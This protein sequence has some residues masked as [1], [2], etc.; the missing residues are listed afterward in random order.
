MEEL[1]FQ[2]KSGWLKLSTEEVDR[3]A[4]GYIK[5]I[6][7]C[8]TE[9]Q[10]VKFAEEILKREGFV[11]V[12]EYGGE[13]PAKVYMKFRDKALVAMKINSKL[14]GGMNLVASHIDS[15]RIDLKPHPIIEDEG[16]ALAKTHY[17]G[18]IK[19]Y[20]WF[21]IPLSIIGVVVKEDGVRIEI[22]LG[23]SEDDPVFVISDLLPHLDRKDEKVS[24]KFK[25]EKMNLILGSVPLNNEEKEAVKL[26]ILRLLNEKYGVKE[27]D[28]VSADLYLVPAFKAREVG[29]D[30]SFI[31]AYGHDDRICAYTSLIALIEA[32]SGKNMGIILFDKEEIGSEGNTGAKSRFYMMFFRKI[33]KKQGFNDVE[34]YLDEALEKTNV[35]SADVNVAINPSF[36]DVHDPANA[37]RAGHGIVITKYTGARGKAGASEARAELVAK[38]RAILNEKGVLWQVGN[39]GKVDVGG[40]GTVAKFLAEKGAEVIDMGPGLIGMHSPYELVSKVDLYESYKAYKALLENL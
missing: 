30:K 14:T 26:N 25:A 7:N 27:E 20:H 38:V 10:T 24:E 28:L 31:G 13:V 17:Y 36:K 1:K 39:L 33:L 22:K 19:K 21:N 5:F 9:R 3:F 37:A 40:G 12:S 8:K 32:S 6:N 4:S 23:E 15:P 29:L 35:I 34:F 18:G 16:I 2:T 11:D